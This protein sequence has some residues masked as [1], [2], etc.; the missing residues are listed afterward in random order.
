VSG[1]HGLQLPALAVSLAHSAEIGVAFVRPVPS[2]G[3]D[4][5]DRSVG[6]DVEQVTDRPEST[7]ALAL[8][9]AE[10]AEL[11]R[12]RERDGQPA[13]VWFTRAWAAKEAVAKTEGTGLQDNP[14]SFVIIGVDVD[15]MQVRVRGSAGNPDRDHH[16][17][18]RDI[19]SPEG[20]P[21]RRYVVAWAEGTDQTSMA[22]RSAHGTEAGTS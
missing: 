7:W 16:V 13:D 11:S 15:E 8:S 4:G 12:A 2:P 9:P 6:I 3:A 18:L 17:T 21:D 20:L 5:A 19:I 14:R 10:R 1:L 22:G